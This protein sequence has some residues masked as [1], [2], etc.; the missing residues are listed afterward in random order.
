M[1]IEGSRKLSILFLVKEERQ[2]GKMSTRRWPRHL[3]GRKKRAKVCFTNN[4]SLQKKLREL[5]GTVP[6]SEEMEDMHTFFQTIQNYI[7]QLE[8]KVRV[9]R[10]LSNLYG[11]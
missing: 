5:Q 8:A 9:L 7:L 3:R 10:C 6:G 1:K 4:A 2:L 11:V